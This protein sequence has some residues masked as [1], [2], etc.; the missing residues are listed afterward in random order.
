MTAG[1]NVAFARRAMFLSPGRMLVALAALGW[2]LLASPWPESLNGSGMVVV[3]ALATLDILLGITTGWLAFKPSSRLDEREM[4]LRNR[5]YRIGFRLIAVGILLTVAL[6]FVVD[7]AT[8]QNGVNHIAAVVP[9]GFSGRLMAAV[10][11]LL[12]I[13]P[14]A[15]IAW[16]QDDLWLGERRLS[17][18]LPLLAVPLLGFFWFAVITLSPV[19]VITKSDSSNT[20]MDMANASCAHYAAEQRVGFGIGGASR[21]GAEVCWNGLKAFVV[22]DPSLTPPAANLPMEAASVPRLPDLVSCT[23]Y[24]GDSDFATV[25]QRCSETIDNLGTM[26]LVVRSTVSPL[27]G[28]IGARELRMELVVDHWGRLVRLQ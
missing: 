23:P 11:E 26:H 6:T 10:V 15:V 18:W 28:G 2:L 12:L 24:P 19:Q 17:G 9:D 22:G 7:M 20:G 21:F 1:K 8:A 4:D 27:P 13:L 25:S 5:A 16:V 3:L 14:T